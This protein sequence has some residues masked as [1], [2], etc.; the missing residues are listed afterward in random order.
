L[1]TAA[2]GPLCPEPAPNDTPPRS[3]AWWPE[4][5][6][7]IRPRT[8]VNCRDAAHG[9]VADDLLYIIGDGGRHRTECRDRMTA[10][11]RSET[12]PNGISLSGRGKGSG[13]RVLACSRATGWWSDL[14]ASARDSAQAAEGIEPVVGSGPMVSNDVGPG[15]ADGAAKHAA[16]DDGVVGVAAHGDQVGHQVDRDDQ[17]ADEQ[18]QVDADTSAKDLR[19]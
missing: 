18:Q 12:A 8:A 4:T 9:G 6:I 11:R 3:Q 15:A 1:W 2:G 19:E 16:D 5:V 14:R 13:P 7:A 17:I 10:P